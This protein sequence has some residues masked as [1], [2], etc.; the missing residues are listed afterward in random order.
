MSAHKIQHGDRGFRLTLP[1][2]YTLSIQYGFGNYCERRSA[3]PGDSEEPEPYS[4]ES[5]DFEL[6]VFYPDEKF[7]S[8]DKSF[9][10][11]T[12]HDA[13]MGYIPFSL[14]GDIIAM[15]SR[16]PSGDLPT[17]PNFVKAFRCWL[18]ALMNEE[19][20]KKHG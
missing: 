11:L 14:L 6:A 5:R 10:Q 16:W 12:E 17:D 18:F 3:H 19:G 9:V 20:K 4:I 1:N 15:I 7:K 13:V 2:G 8:I